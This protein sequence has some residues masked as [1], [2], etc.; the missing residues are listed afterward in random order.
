MSQIIAS[1]R[2]R[3][4]RKNKN[5][6]CLIV[7]KTGSGKSYSALELAKLIDPSFNIDRIVFD[8]EGFMRLLNSGELKRGNS[9]VWDECGVSIPS[10]EFMSVLNR[11][12]NYILQS[13]RRENLAVIFTVPD[14]SFI[15]IQTRKLCH[16]EIET[17]SINYQKELVVCK[18]L[19]IDSSPRFNKV[20]YKYPVFFENGKQKTIKQFLIP[21]PNEDIISAYEEKRK[22]FLKDLSMEVESKIKKS[23]EVKPV[24]NLQSI[25]DEVR[26]NIDSFSTVKSNKKV[27]DKFLIMGKYPIARDKAEIVKKVLEAEINSKVVFNKK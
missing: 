21:K 18:Y 13:F 5:F 8:A 25:I 11:S 20:Y 12:I 7:G 22:Q 27:V 17:V 4:L 26:G 19:V 9:I 3:I 14:P 1:I 23:K 6:L 24:I 16:A 10:R 2:N 15:D